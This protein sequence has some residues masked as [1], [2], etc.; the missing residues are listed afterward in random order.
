MAL[1]TPELQGFDDAD[2][3][4]G[5]WSSLKKGLKAGAKGGAWLAGG[6]AGAAVAESLLGGKKKRKKA[7]PPPPPPPPPPKKTGLSTAAKVGIGIGATIALLVVVHL[8]TRKK[9]RTS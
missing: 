8:A 7:P 2:D 9:G 1:A 4:A 5:F 3:V 6:A